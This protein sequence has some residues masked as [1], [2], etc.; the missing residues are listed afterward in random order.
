M[1]G[2]MLPCDSTKHGVQQTTKTNSQQS[3]S[4]VAKPGTVPD[5]PAWPERNP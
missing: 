5:V 1:V 2:I 3:E 4:G